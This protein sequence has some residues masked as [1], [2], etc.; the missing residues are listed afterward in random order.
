MRGR[1]DD[2]GVSARRVILA[3][4]E[5]G[6]SDA[7]VP[8]RVA[9]RVRPVQPADHARP[10]LRYLARRRARRSPVCTMFPRRE[11][12]MIYTVRRAWPHLT[13]PERVVIDRK[14]TRLNS[15]HLVISYAVF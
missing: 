15:S 9:Q 12:P 11:P 4:V 6:R 2:H 8:R 10:R 5:S 13:R 14:S 1:A 7:E 3:A